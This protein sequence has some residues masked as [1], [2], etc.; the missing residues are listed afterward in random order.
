MATRNAT[1][2]QNGEPVLWVMAH[3]TGRLWLI[4]HIMARIVASRIVRT[5]LVITAIGAYNGKKQLVI[6]T[7]ALSP[8]RPIK[9]KIGARNSEM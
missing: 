7:I 2:L 9:L 6:K 1:I 3:S 4:K 8:G 5:M